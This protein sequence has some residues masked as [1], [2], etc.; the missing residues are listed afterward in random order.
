LTKTTVRV[1]HHFLLVH[2]RRDFSGPTKPVWLVWLVWRIRKRTLLG[3]GA[4]TLSNASLLWPQPW[5]GKGTHLDA[6]VPD[7]ASP[8]ASNLSDPSPLCPKPR[9][10]H[11]RR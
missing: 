7:R 9:P 4:P 3:V 8:R 2:Q 11:A 5:R 1:Q 6:A 10:V